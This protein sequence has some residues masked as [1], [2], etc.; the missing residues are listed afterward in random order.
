MSERLWMIFGTIRPY[1]WLRIDS[2][3]FVNEVSHW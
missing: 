3:F 1:W 2:D